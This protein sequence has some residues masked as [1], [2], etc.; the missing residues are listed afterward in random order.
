MTPLHSSE[1]SDIFVLNF[2]GVFYSF[3]PR[4]SMVSSKECLS[5]DCQPPELP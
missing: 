5:Q 2:H 4:S 3:C 1:N